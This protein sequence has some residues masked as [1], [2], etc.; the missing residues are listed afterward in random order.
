MTFSV[1]L[2]KILAGLPFR[3]ICRLSCS[4]LRPDDTAMPS[5]VVYSGLLRSYWSENAL[6][7]KLPPAIATRFASMLNFSD[8]ASLRPASLLPPPAR[9]TAEG[10]P[11]LSSVTRLTIS[12]ARCPIGSVSSCSICAR[13]T[14]SSK[15][16]ILVKLKLSCAA[17]CILICSAV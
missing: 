14:V 8:T 7:R 12:P 3:R 17:Y 13:L 15:P 9:N 6:R 2:L 11:L 5:G 1:P 10:A 16:R 4:S